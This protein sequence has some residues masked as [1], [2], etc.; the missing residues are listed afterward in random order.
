MRVDP[1]LEAADLGPP[2]QRA[3]LAV[4]ALQPGMVVSHD[5]LAEAVWDGRPPRTFAHSLQLYVSGLRR[6]LTR[7][8]SSVDIETLSQGYRLVVP[9]EDVDLIRFRKLVDAGLAAAADDWATA[10]DQLDAGLALCRGPTLVDFS[11]WEFAAAIVASVDALRLDA[12][13]ALAAGRHALGDEA[14]A[15]RA[16]REVLATDPL[17]ER[18]VGILMQALYR[19]GRT[20]ES[21]RAYEDLRRTLDD[22]LGAVP[23]HE[24]RRLHERI[25]RHDESLLVQGL[26]TTPPGEDPEPPVERAGPSRA[27]RPWRG[28]LAAVA[29]TIVAG[30]VGISLAMGSS[31]G[32]TPPRTAFLLH[33]D[34]GEVNLLV[35]AGFEDGVSDFDLVGK[36]LIPEGASAELE[37]DQSDVSGS[38]VV[39]FTLGTDLAAAARRHPDAYFV[40][41]DDYA[42]TSAPNLATVRFSTHE[43]SYLAGFAAARTTKTGIVGFIGGVDT[44]V[45]WPFEAGYVAGVRAADPDVEVRVAY[46][47]SP[48]RFGEGFQNPR[49]GERSASRMF[50]AGA[51][52]VFAAAGTSGLGVIEAATQGSTDQRHLWAIG[53]DSDQYETVM[54]LPGTVDAEGWQRHILTSVVKRFD[55]A[56]YGVLARFARDDFTAGPLQYDLED[57]GVDISYSGGHI[58]TLRAELEEVRR[59]VVDDEIPVPC[60]PERIETDP[61]AAC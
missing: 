21:L 45:I 25:L 18:A 47:S 27:Q 46:L 17:K 50:D 58:E 2:K 51:D 42:D 44:D 1:G 56:V 60:I 54:R 38:I 11:S 15:A 13:E 3:L 59:G 43:A 49:A 7:A 37:I 53:V 40:A 36:Q 10:V 35:K 55:R 6:V 41:L 57:G 19:S 22:E 24:L 14:A 23:S 29:A 9:P 39:D 5:A 30:A 34:D 4:L 16:A 32:P 28:G 48:P 12:L 31:G 26:P 52:V 8:G 33:H 20:A 61:P